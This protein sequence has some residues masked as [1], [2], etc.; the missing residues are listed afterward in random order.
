M[1]CYWNTKW[2]CLHDKCVAEPGQYP[3]YYP[4]AQRM[5]DS[6]QPSSLRQQVAGVPQTQL[7]EIVS[8]LTQGQNVSEP[9]TPSTI[10]EQQRQVDPI[11]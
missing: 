2:Y 7:N 5:I 1:K 10:S 8:N 6:F 9:L 3:T 4:I 11:V